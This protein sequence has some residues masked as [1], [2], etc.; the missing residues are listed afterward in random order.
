[1]GHENIMGR[2][3]AK[4]AKQGFTIVELLVVIAIIALLFA[5][6]VPSLSRV[7]MSATY[8][9]CGSNLAQ[10]VK[11]GLIYLDDNKEVF[12]EDPNEWLY[13]KASV[14]KEHPIGCRWHDRAMSYAG[15]YQNVPEQYQGKMWKY[16]TE[17]RIGLCPIF[18]DIAKY[19]G[20]ENPEHN[21]NLD[22]VPQY[23]YTMNAYLGSRDNGGVRNISEVRKPG[24]VFFFAEESSWSVRP[25][26]PKFPAK[27]LNAP[28]S[29]KALD[30]TILLI[31][32]TPQARDCFAGY[33]R[34]SSDDLSDGSCN[35][36]FVDGHVRMVRVEE[37]LRQKMH[38]VRNPEN[39]AGN[40]SMGW[41]S[42]T[43][44]PGGWD[45]Q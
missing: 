20:C 4:N 22:I 23:C 21:N 33:H 38:K 27:W 32:P 44:P 1:M 39:P 31:T 36:A 28:L 18:R 45:G 2:A 37:Q 34:A 41:A 3:I 35:V 40:M 15:E 42:K 9:I 19:R 16:I 5:L 11:T 30:D 8:M 29:T 7:R 14:S 43:P 24:E 6:L 25:D 12:P 10:L 26:H 17:T 13:A